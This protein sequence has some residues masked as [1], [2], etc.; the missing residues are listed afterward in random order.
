MQGWNP[1]PIL[2]TV[3][4]YNTSLMIPYPATSNI[5]LMMQDVIKS[6]KKYLSPFAFHPYSQIIK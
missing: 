6:V 3:V 5:L 1:S 4:T 2:R